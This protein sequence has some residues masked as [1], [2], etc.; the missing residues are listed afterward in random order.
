MASIP[1]YFEKGTNTNMSYYPS[2][3]DRLKRIQTISKIKK[4]NNIDNNSCIDCDNKPYYQLSNIRWNSVLLRNLESG[5]TYPSD[6]FVKTIMNTAII[7]KQIINPP[8]SFKPKYINRISYIPLYYNKLLI[9]DALMKQGSYPRYEFGNKYIY[10]EHSGVITLRDGCVD[11][12]VVSAETDRT[13]EN[14]P[15]IFLPKNTPSLF[16]NEFLFHTH[17]NTNHNHLKRI[18]EGILYEFPSANDILNFVRCQREGKAQA[19]IVIATEG[20][21]VI[22]P[23]VYKRRLEIDRVFYQLLRKYIIK[24][25]KFAIKKYLPDKINTL[26]NP[27]IFHKTV[28]LDFR[29]INL[30]NKFIAPQNLFVEYYP[31]EKKNSEWCLRPITLTLFNQN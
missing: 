29:P 19:S 9:L 7:D 24:L 23:L 13:D 14:D 6:F 22:R 4:S 2:F 26:A 5:L 1:I 8:I 15:D 16:E 30:Y 3:I 21:Y 25:E 28:G 12:I 11:N 17:P 20:I 10:S 31:R 27:D 18:K